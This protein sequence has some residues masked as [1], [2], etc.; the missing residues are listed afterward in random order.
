MIDWSAV[1]GPSNAT[2]LLE[3]SSGLAGF[4]P[5]IGF[6]PTIQKDGEQTDRWVASL[7]HIVQR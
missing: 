6:H 7:S 3:R 1:T 5:L 2:L 4:A